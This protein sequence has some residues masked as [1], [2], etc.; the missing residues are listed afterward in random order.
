MWLLGQIVVVLIVALVALFGL[1]LLGRLL[2]LVWLLWMAY[3]AKEPAP[4]ITPYRPE[5]LRGSTPVDD[6]VPG[7][8]LREALDA[9]R[10]KADADECPAQQREI[11]KA[12]EQAAASGKPHIRGPVAKVRAAEEKP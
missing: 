8:L 6:V 4:P 1:V 9:V 5:T 7:P 11:A 2:F 10:V 3:V 12:I